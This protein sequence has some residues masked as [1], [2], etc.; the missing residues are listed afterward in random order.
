MR[1]YKIG[2]VEIRL[3]V[4]QLLCYGEADI[5]SAFNK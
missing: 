5:N 4:D 2:P 1:D 3:Q